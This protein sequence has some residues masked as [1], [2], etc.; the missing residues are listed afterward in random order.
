MPR[1]KKERGRPP[2]KPLPPRIQAT[3]EQLAQAL[4]AMPAYHKWKY[5]ENGP[6]DYRCAECGT[7]AQYPQVLTQSGLCQD[8]ARQVKATD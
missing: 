3:P 4:F 6:P 8:C 1:K 2:S 5:L 7:E